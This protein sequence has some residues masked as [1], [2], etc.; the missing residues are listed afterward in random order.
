MCSDKLGQVSNL[1]VRGIP[2]VVRRSPDEPET[3]GEN[4]AVAENA[5]DRQDGAEATE[6]P[7]QKDSKDVDEIQRAQKRVGSCYLVIKCITRSGK[8]KNIFQ[9]KVEHCYCMQ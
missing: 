9:T 8:Q 4:G 1:A 3:E 7:F 5:G 6:S 2:C